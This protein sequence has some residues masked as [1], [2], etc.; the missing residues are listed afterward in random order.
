MFCDFK[1][2]KRKRKQSVWK[3]SSPWH[4][5]DCVYNSC[6]HQPWPVL[7]QGLSLACSDEPG[8][9]L[10]GMHTEQTFVLH[11]SLL[12]GRAADSGDSGQFAYQKILFWNL[13]PL[14]RTSIQSRSAGMWTRHK[15]E[16]QETPGWGRKVEFMRTEAN[17]WLFYLRS[18][19]RHQR[20]GATFLFCFVFLNSICTDTRE[21]H[22]K[23]TMLDVNKSDYRVWVWSHIDSSLNV[24][25]P[26]CSPV[27]LSQLNSKP[28]FPHL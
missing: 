22:K 26:L 17:T 24:V 20:A 1:K 9:S 23:D 10:S 6:I 12:M 15:M 5:W 11:G 2:K 28:L 3:E 4:G 21:T 27:N 13:R 16:M 8:N 19:T 18:T 25:L 7:M 14:S